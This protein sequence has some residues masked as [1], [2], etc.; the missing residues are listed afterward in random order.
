MPQKP[1]KNNEHFVDLV[2]S[3][4]VSIP[5]TSFLFST[6]MASNAAQI[7]TLSVLPFSKKTFR[8]LNRNIAQNWW[9]LVVKTSKYFHKVEVIYTGDEIPLK[10]NAIVIANHQQMSDTLFI[11]FFALEKE[12]LGDLKWF[13]KD[14]VKYFPG[15]GWGLH[16][17]DCIFVKRNWTRDR[18]SIAKTFSKFKKED[19]PLWLVSFS[20]GTRITPEKL[21]KSQEYAVD[22]NLTVTDHVMLPRT[23]GFVASINGLRDHIDAVYD[24]TIGYPDGVPTMWQYLKGMAK[25]AHF[26]IRRFPVEE[27]PESQDELSKWL[28]NRFQEKD[29]L[30]DIFYQTGSFSE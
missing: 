15:V 28:I 21:E 17:V 30:L 11:F 26:H 8:K 22:H 16:F 20:E 9:E 14:V 27:L 10:E 7:C 19:I 29:S 6:L 12:R 23:K 2:K 1:L 25:Q 18:D 5:L 24:I 3:H 4:L 13:A